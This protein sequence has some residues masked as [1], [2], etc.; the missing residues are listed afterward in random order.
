MAKPKHKKVKQTDEPSSSSPISSLT[1]SQESM[2][3]QS[4]SP[5]QSVDSDSKRVYMKDRQKNG[6]KENA[7]SKSSSHTH[8]SP[9]PKTSHMESGPSISPFLSTTEKDNQF[10]AGKNVNFEYAPKQDTSSKPIDRGASPFNSSS[11]PIPSSSHHEEHPSDIDSFD[12]S[13]KRRHHSPVNPTQSTATNS[14]PAPSS[15]LPPPFPPLLPLSAEKNIFQEFLQSKE[16]AK[17]HDT[18][19]KFAQLRLQQLQNNQSALTEEQRAQIQYFLEHQHLLQIPPSSSI[20][21]QQILAS[22]QYAANVNA[23]SS[24]ATVAAAAALHQ[25]KA[26]DVFELLNDSDNLST[27][28]SNPSSPIQINGSATLASRDPHEWCNDHSHSHS[29]FNN[30]VNNNG[31]IHP[32]TPPTPSPSYSGTTSMILQQQLQQQ[33]HQQQQQQQLQLQI[34]QQQLQ[35]QSSS[36]SANPK[37]FES[38]KIWDTS[39]TEEKERIRQFWHGLSYDERREL[40]KIPKHIVMQK[41]KEQKKNDCNCVMCGKK[42][43]AMEELESLYDA[44]SEIEKY[45]DLRH[46]IEDSTDIDQKSEDSEYDLQENKKEIFNLGN[47]LTIQGG[48]LTV[49]DDLLKNDGKKFIDM[50]DHLQARRQR[51]EEEEVQAIAEYEVDANIDDEDD[52]GEY[53]DDD[54]KYEEDDMEDYEGDVGS[55]EEFEDVSF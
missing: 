19:K 20:S 46:R 5:P 21:E 12:D 7:S 50:M 14:S 25:F 8:S 47:T 51:R 53:T 44:Y 49:A 34:Q 15:P 38:D 48:I 10:V 17:I 1:P 9:I 55:E 41:V 24:L 40:V 28:N 26:K 22:E 35:Q 52:M 36:S 29:H 31:G 3:S 27:T 37:R 11:L 4:S 45:S 33:Q 2:A 13:K 42:R 23:I 16:V 54:G 6:V 43:L 18:A 30:N 32:S 39:N